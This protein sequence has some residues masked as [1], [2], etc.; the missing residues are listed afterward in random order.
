[1]AFHTTEN[2]LLWLSGEHH[3]L[4]DYLP[5]ICFFPYNMEPE[6]WSVDVS[7]NL[8]THFGGR[9]QTMRLGNNRESNLRGASS[10]KGVVDM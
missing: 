10:F 8:G 3:C 6:H 4:L 7:L 5:Y 2:N 1:M 9:K